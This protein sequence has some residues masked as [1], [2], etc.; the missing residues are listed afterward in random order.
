MASSAKFAA[1]LNLLQNVLSLGL[2]R[3]IRLARPRPERP[4]SECAARVP[5]PAPSTPLVR[6]VVLL[7]LLL[8]RLLHAT[9]YIVRRKRK[10]ADRPLFRH[11]IR[12]ARRIL[13]EE[14]FQLRIRRI[15][16]TCADRPLEITA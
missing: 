12:I 9:R 8:R 1:L 2:C 15:D 4:G 13:L 5:A 6:V 16:L 10:V 14:R 7:N 11:G 3:R